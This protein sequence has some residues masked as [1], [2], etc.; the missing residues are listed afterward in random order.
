MD[1][2]ESFEMQLLIFGSYIFSR[3][4]TMVNKFKCENEYKELKQGRFFKQEFQSIKHDCI[5]GDLKKLENH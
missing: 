2:D 3:N 5:Q 4:A 1:A